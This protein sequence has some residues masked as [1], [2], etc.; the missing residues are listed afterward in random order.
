MLRLGLRVKKS[1]IQGA[2]RGLFAAKAFRS[3]Q[4]IV[5]YV[6]ASKL[7]ASMRTK[8]TIDKRYPGNQ[9]AAYVICHGKQAR[10]LCTD[11]SKTSSGVGRF[12]NDVPGINNA[13]FEW[14]GKRQGHVLVA[15]RHIAAGEEIFAYYGDSYW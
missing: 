6:A 11:A 15:T 12:A 4:R 8:A 2:G 3:G 7:A 13:E 1:T 5:P 10:S 9:V 14:K